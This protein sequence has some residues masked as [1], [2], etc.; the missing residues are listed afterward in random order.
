MVELLNEQGKAVKG[1]RVLLL[2]LAYKKNTGDIREAPSL[3]IAELLR[4]L[5]ATISAVDDH[6]ESHRWPGGVIKSV[7]SAETVDEADIVVL[8]TDHD[9]FTYDLLTRD[10]AVVLDT[11]NRLAGT[12]VHT[13]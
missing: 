1:S 10:H 12:K 9:E 7:L 6:V 5:G 2:G 8:L 13:L 4:G 3:R 11:K